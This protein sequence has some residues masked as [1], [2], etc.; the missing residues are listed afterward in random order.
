MISKKL[1]AERLTLL[2]QRRKPGRSSNTAADSVRNVVRL[3]T[4]MALGI[5]VPQS[6]LLRAD[7]VIQ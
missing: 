3:K 7:E 6:L 4:A 5:P 2:R 1:D